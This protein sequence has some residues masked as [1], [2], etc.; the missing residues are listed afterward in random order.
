MN[1]LTKKEIISQQVANKRVSGIV[2]VRLGEVIERDYEEFL[3]LISEKL[4]GTILLSDINYKLVGSVENDSGGHNLLISVSGDAGDIISDICPG[5]DEDMIST[6]FDKGII[7]L[8]DSPYGDGPV[9]RIGEYW[10]YFCADA[11]KPDGAYFHADDYLRIR[12]ED[13]TVHVIAAALKELREDEET[14][15]ETLYY[16]LYL[17]EHGCGEKCAN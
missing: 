5:I 14:Y 13:H 17:R 3:D 16:E 6:G 8:E 10:F 11:E 4:V 2:S 1:L 7:S 15:E 9:C 12:G